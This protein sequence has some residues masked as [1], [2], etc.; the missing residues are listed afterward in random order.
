MKDCFVEVEVE[1]R[2]GESVCPYLTILCNQH[3]Y[4][5]RNAIFARLSA[6]PFRTFP[7]LEANFVPL[8][9]GLERRVH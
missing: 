7:A 9:C 2:Q 8:A 5:F 4:Y 1:S 6:R 3:H